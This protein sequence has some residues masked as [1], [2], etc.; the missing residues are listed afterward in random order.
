MLSKD[1][2]LILLKLLM[3]S[4]DI[5]VII[6]AKKNGNL[7]YK[8]LSIIIFSFMKATDKLAYTPIG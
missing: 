4:R 5:A 3:T 8:L 2:L 7:D 6:S 1:K